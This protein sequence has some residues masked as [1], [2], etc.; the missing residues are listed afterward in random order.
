MNKEIK[1]LWSNLGGEQK[2]K[3]HFASLAKIELQ[4]VKKQDNLEQDRQELARICQMLIDEIN[5]CEDRV[6]VAEAVIGDLK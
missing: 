6:K 1:D 3:K 5:E 4:W 2:H